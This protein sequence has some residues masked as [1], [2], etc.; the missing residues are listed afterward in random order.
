MAKFHECGLPHEVLGAGFKHSE[1]QQRRTSNLNVE[2][3]ESQGEINIQKYY[4]VLR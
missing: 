2:E 1:L 3:L 4:E